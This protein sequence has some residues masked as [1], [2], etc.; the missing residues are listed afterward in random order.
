[1]GRVYIEEF[2]YEF[3]LKSSLKVTL[4]MLHA[5]RILRRLGENREYQETLL[6][7]SAPEILVA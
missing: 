3:V 7:V 5:K 6:E 2:V 4:I 1:M